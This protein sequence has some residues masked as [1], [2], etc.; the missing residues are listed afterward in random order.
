MEYWPEDHGFFFGRMNIEH[1]TLLAGF[2]GAN[3]VPLE[4]YFAASLTDPVMKQI[5]SM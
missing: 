2:G 5:R 1:I 3:L 4:D